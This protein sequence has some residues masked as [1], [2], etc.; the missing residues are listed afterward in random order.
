V[1]GWFSTHW[2]KMLSDI[3]V[4]TA[5]DDNFWMAKAY[6]MPTVPVKPGD[7][8]FP[9]VPV[10]AMGPRSFVTG[11][12]DGASVARGAEIELRGIAMGGD[13]AVERVVVLVDGKAYP[14]TLQPDDTVFGFRKWAVK[15]PPISATTSISVRATNATGMSQ[16]DAQPWNPSG[17]ARNLAE[18]ITVRIS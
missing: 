9:T 14:A 6:R 8:G 5:E 4:L 10:T 16:P 7:K 2:V 3:E 15:L 13:A 11:Q 17:Y 12:M 1:P 18:H